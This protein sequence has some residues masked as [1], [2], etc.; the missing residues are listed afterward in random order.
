MLLLM[1]RRTLVSS[2]VVTAAA[3]KVKAAHAE[4]KPYIGILGPYTPSNVEFAKAQGYTNMI[5]GSGPDGTLDAQKIT[6]AQIDSVKKT[7]KANG[8]HVSA[9]QVGGN[10]ISGDAA[11]RA[12]DNA[13]FQKAIELAGHL[14]VP[15][16][17]AM[18]GK[19]RALPFPKQVD[20]IVRVYNEKYFPLCQ[21]NKVRICWEPW[22]EGRISPPARWGMTRFST[23]LTT[24][25]TSAC[26]LIPLTS[27]ASS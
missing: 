21:K 16:I 25:H 9:L 24:R 26:S 10:H 8:I 14:N 20:E 23:R 7:L 17:G 18:S 2:L 5:L 6:D 27:C 11:E 15:Y 12:S 13:Y 4:W 19:N 22:P 3:M 1:T